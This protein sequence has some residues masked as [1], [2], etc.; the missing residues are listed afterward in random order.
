MACEKAR[1]WASAKLWL[2]LVTVL[3]VATAGV[4]G[5]FLSHTYDL[6]AAVAR[7][8]TATE[9]QE[10]LKETLT[11]T[12]TPVLLRVTELE[13]EKVAWERRQR[14]YEAALTRRQNHSRKI[15]PLLE[16]A[17]RLEGQQDIYAAM[18]V[19]CQAAEVDSNSPEV[20]NGLEEITEAVREKQEEQEYISKIR[21]Y[22]FV[23]KF[24]SRWSDEKVPGIEFKL[25]NNGDR[26][27]SR[28]VVTVY[29]QDSDGKTIYEEKWHPVSSSSW[30]SS[31]VLRPGYIWQLE[32]NKFYPV[33]K[34]P[35]EWQP[36]PEAA[37]AKI[38]DI[39]FAEE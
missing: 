22:D 38:T 21:L 15:A 37:Y 6:T 39:E 24:Y 31:S 16:K 26:T 5:F 30:T 18:K 4:A 29:F 1:I 35:T 20:A 8:K 32:R 11:N 19:W 12:L 13:D 7:L 33:E 23:A 34:L 17:R 28:I 2:G 36:S 10:D 3:W 27:L 14:E 9:E 25:Q